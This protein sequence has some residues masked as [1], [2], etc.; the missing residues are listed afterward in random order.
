MTVCARCRHKMFPTTTINLRYL[1]TQ[2][3]FLVMLQNVIQVKCLLF[4]AL[5]NV[6]VLLKL[7][8]SDKLI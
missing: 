1:N 2:I 4:Q 8:Q 5:L 7:Q 6:S 3:A